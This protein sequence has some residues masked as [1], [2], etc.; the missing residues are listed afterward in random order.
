MMADDIAVLSRNKCL[1]RS[2][3]T[4]GICTSFLNI[5]CRGVGKEDQLLSALPVEWCYRR[6]ASAEGSLL[7]GLKIICPLLQKESH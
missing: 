4:I 5:S 1:L 2:S 7:G 3:W 6:E